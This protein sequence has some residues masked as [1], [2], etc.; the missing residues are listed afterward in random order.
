[1]PPQTRR[2]V[3]PASTHFP[4][5][6]N[7]D[8]Q[9][10]VERARKDGLLRRIWLGDP[11][12]GRALPEEN[13]VLGVIGRS[14]GPQMRVPILVARGEIG[15]P[16]ISTDRIVAIQDAEGDWCYRHPRLDLGEWS[17]A[18]LR[19]PEEPGLPYEVSCSGTTQA[20]F[21]QEWQAAGYMAFM[22]GESWSQRY[23]ADERSEERRKEDRRTK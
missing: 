13:D 11:E 15:G 12:T 2:R 16:Q 6:T 7:Y 19:K 10:E 17:S 3:E 20:F 22:Q 18:R 8:V 9:R 21:A 5:G 1:M 14:C 23:L 4:A